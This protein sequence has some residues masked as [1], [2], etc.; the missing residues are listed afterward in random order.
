[1]AQAI[2]IRPHRWSGIYIL[3]SWL[4]FVKVKEPGIRTHGIGPRQKRPSDRHRLDID[5]TL[6]RRIDVYSMSI[7]W[8]L[9]SGSSLP[10]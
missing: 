8:S 6:S 9:L 7:R 2:E 3:Q 4:V 5:P 1:M 10:G